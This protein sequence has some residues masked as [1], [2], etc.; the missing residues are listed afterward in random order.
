[1]SLEP[2]NPEELGPPVGYSH[3]MLAP[4]GVR[5]LFVAGQ[6]GWDREQRLVAAELAPQFAQALRNVVQVVERA[7]GRP[8]HLARLTIYVTDRAEYIA[9][10][11]EIGRRYREIMGRHYPAMA[12]LVVR[13]LLDP[14]AKVEIEATAAIPLAGPAPPAP[15]AAS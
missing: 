13:G 6:V 14:A 7:G 2:I 15:A 9:A 1:M 5:L 11:R 3:G 12:L 8:E 4:P 10:R